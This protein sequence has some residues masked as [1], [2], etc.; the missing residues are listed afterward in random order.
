MDIIIQAN[1]IWRSTMRNQ[2]DARLSFAY[3]AYLKQPEEQIPSKAVGCV[4]IVL[5]PTSQA[6]HTGII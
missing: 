1:A 6:L 4:C 3:L 2:M 5:L